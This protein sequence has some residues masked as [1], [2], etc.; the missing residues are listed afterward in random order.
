MKP[1]FAR[2]APLAALG[3]AALW[4]CPKGSGAGARNFTI[5]AINDVYRIEGLVESDTGGLARVRALRQA[6]EAQGK[7]VLVLHAGDLVGPS[8]MSRLYNGDQMIQGLG[9]LDGDPI[10]RDE[11]MFVT[12]G[13]HEF[14]HSK[15]KD[16]PALDAQVEASGFNWVSS[17]VIFSKGDDGAPLVA[18]DNLVED[19]IIEVGGVKVGLIGVTIDSKHPD[20]VSEFLDPATVLRAHTA[21]LRERGAEVVVGLTHLAMAEDESLLRTLGAAGPDLIIGGHDHARQC[22]DIDGRPVY[23][24]DADAAT[25]TV[26]DV[27]LSPGKPTTLS[28]HYAFLGGKPESS[29]EV[30]CKTRP[31]DLDVQPDPTVAAWVTERQ[32]I[33]DATWC[34]E[35]LGKQPGCL[36]EKLTT[37]T[38]RFV[39]EE[40]RI[41]RYETSGG[42]WVT[43]RMLAAF[44]AQGAQIALMNS[45]GL[46]L[47]QDVPAGASMTLRHVEELIGFPTPLRLIRVKGSTLQAVLDHA[48]SDWT[49]NGHWLQISGFA[50]V[51]DPGA[52]TATKLTLLDPK[53]ARLISPDEELLAVVPDFLVDPSQGQDGYTMLSPSMIVQTPQSPELKALLMQDLSAAGE[54]GIH[55]EQVG[56]ICNTLEPGA[57]L[58]VGH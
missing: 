10:A 4:G 36:S 3:L 42:D 9:M 18:A 16:A 27:G 30:R 6:L 40:E 44:S 52:G 20:Y 14:D 53:G 23:K 24:A 57:C 39:A 13:N 37:T 32:K 28:H 46:R 49:G 54:Q 2:I 7:D 8:F 5:L 35:K 33:F 43:D 56:R 25:T 38:T 41:R 19:A 48:I 51:H 50:Y 1:Y 15:L 17:N 29:P 58:A 47:N 22:A 34:T 31:L 45:G 11:H 12:F 21:G 26:L 55:P